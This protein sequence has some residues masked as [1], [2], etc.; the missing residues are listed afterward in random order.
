M[1]AVGVIG[2]GSIGLLLAGKL[3]AAGYDVTIWTR[4]QRQ[5]DDLNRYGITLE[6]PTGMTLHQSR[7]FAVHYTEATFFKHGPILLAVK[8]TALTSELYKQLART[9]PVGGSLVLFQNGIGH[10]ERLQQEL[11]NRHIVVAVTTEAALRLNGTTVRHTGKGETQLGEWGSSMID[12]QENQHTNRLVDSRK[13]IND[14]EGVLQEAGFTAFLSNQLREA[15][16]RK[17]LVNAVINPLTALLR[18]TNGDL[19]VTDER[20]A[21]MHSLFT[22]TFVILQAH[23]LK[24]QQSLWQW[25][26]QVCEQTKDNESSMLQDIKA[27]RMT[28]VDA[29]N[30]AICQLARQQGLEAPLNTMITALIQASHSNRRE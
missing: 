28:E 11:P 25:V 6:D 1:S 2:G 27:N 7:V 23:G 19:I 26:V 21:L 29:I 8:Q 10:V 5:A 24:E 9:V 17:L 13:T 4:T 12:Q 3:S 30:G 18:V 22:E 16:M 20:I 14:V 15:V